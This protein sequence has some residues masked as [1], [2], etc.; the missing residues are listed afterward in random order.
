MN[1]LK[2]VNFLKNIGFC[3]K[4]PLIIYI[5]TNDAHISNINCIFLKFHYLR[6]DKL[7]C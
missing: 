5:Y 4:I 7:K 1:N 6:L 3:L 2:L